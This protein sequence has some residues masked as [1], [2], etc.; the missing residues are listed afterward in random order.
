[1][2]AMSGFFLSLVVGILSSLI[3]NWLYDKTRKR[4]K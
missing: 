2:S 4:G 3:A 1:V